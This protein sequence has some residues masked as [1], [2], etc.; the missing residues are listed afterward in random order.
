MFTWKGSF[1]ARPNSTV[2][3]NGIISGEVKPGAVPTVEST[4]GAV[5]AAEY[6]VPNRQFICTAWTGCARVLQ[7]EEPAAAATCERRNSVHEQTAL[8]AVETG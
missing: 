2:Y 3:M 1:Q 6:S 5:N 7:Q 4:A 8:G